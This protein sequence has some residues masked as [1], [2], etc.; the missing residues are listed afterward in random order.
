MQLATVAEAEK[1][2]ASGL[3]VRSLLRIPV[4]SAANPRLPFRFCPQFND[5]DMVIEMKPAY[6]ERKR[7]ER[8]AKRV[9]RKTDEAECV[10]ES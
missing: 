3:K 2:A 5:V 8:K 7:S 6:H 10:C 1:L 4:L 9:E